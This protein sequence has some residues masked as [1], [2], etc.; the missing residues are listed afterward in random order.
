MYELLA[1][2]A[3]LNSASTTTSLRQEFP[4]IR[5][6]P[7][8][9]WPAFRSIFQWIYGRHVSC[10]VS[11]ARESNGVFLSNVHAAI[12]HLYN[13]HTKGFRPHS[14]TSH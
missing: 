9:L 11:F 3:I 10:P 1:L 6:K 14:S 5:Q 2:I 8:E 13:H 7:A 12:T 4:R